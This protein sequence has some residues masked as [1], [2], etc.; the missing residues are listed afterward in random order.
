VYLILLKSISRIHW[1]LH[2]E[3]ILLLHEEFILLLHEEFIVLHPVGCLVIKQLLVQADFKEAKE[4][5]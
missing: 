1:I 2:E 5:H 4:V 3:F